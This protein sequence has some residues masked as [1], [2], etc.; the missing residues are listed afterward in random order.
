MG[1]PVQKALDSLHKAGVGLVAMKVMAGGLRGRKPRPEMQRENAA[2][3]A[4]KWV[5]KNPAISTTV[6]SMTDVD[7]L[8][9][10][11]Q[12]MSQSFSDAD[13]KTLTARLEE[14]RPEYC[15]MCG[16]CDGRCPRGLPVSDVLRYLTYAEGYGQF[17]LGRER[18]LELPAEIAQVRCGECPS[19]PIQCPNG[20]RVTD[21]LIRA[22]ELFA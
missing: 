16:S 15:R 13:A 10:N 19:C 5:I 1:E 21:R 8:E 9:Q 4:L 12:V 22:Q 11:F 7:Q 3:A 6:P 17:P 14:I 20:V 2:A 18:F